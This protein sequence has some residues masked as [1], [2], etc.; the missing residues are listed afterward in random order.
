MKMK[1]FITIIVLLAGI[2]CI[3]FFIVDSGRKTHRMDLQTVLLMAPKRF[4]Y[5]DEK[6]KYKAA[7]RQEWDRLNSIELISDSEAEKRAF[8]LMKGIH[9]SRVD[10]HLGYCRNH[11]KYYQQLLKGRPEGTMRDCMDLIASMSYDA[12]DYPRD[13]AE[14]RKLVYMAAHFLMENISHSGEFMQ[15]CFDVMFNV[16][17]SSSSHDGYMISYEGAVTDVLQF[18]DFNMAD[19]MLKVAEPYIDKMSPSV[20]KTQLQNTKT[21]YYPIVKQRCD[22]QKRMQE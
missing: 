21:E 18:C 3:L 22:A 10:D 2:G 12:Y 9:C 8:T 11:E 6:E 15:P 16:T 7:K 17:S 1:F 4:P 13:S 20:Y 19:K 14:Q 5:V